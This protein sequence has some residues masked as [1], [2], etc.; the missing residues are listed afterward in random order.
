MS[1]R[2]VDQI[3]GLHQYVAAPIC[4]A[5]A[6]VGERHTFVG[7]FNQ[8]NTQKFFQ[9]TNT[10]AQRG[11]GDVEVARGSAKMEMIIKRNKVLKLSYWR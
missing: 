3:F 1:L 4:N 6:K 10:R 8:L 11:L 7:S 9:L 5:R 2:F